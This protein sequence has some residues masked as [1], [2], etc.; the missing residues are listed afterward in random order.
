M[1]L[2]WTQL[3]YSYVAPTTR[4]NKSAAVKKH[5]EDPKTLFELLQRAARLWPNHGIAFKD[6]GW[7]QKSD[8][9]TYADLLREAEV[10]LQQHE[11]AVR[12]ADRKV[13]CGQTPGARN[14]YAA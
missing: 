2:N 14:C 9:L 4:N 8:F 11:I 7:D 5:G 1:I 12:I 3:I 10:R 6:H 13:Q